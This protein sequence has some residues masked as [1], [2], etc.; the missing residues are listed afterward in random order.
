MEQE[1]MNSFERTRQMPLYK[2]GE[3]IIKI[4]DRMLDLVPED[5][6]ELKDTVQWMRECSMTLCVKISGAEG[7]DLYAHRMECATLIRKAAHE[8]IINLHSLAMFGYTHTEFFPLLRNAVE[9]YRVLFVEWV[10]SFDQWNYIIDR[11][12]LFNPPGVTAHDK[13]PDD[14]IPFSAD[15]F[16]E[17]FDPEDGDDD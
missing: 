15:E 4:V 9:E 16:F 8:L 14:D 3:E 6:E 12:G 17:N 10:E 13:D 5:N 11:W 2:K 1:G 7:G